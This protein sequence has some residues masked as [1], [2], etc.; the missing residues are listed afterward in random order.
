MELKFP[1]RLFSA[2]AGALILALASSPVRSYAELGGT[3]KVEATAFTTTVTHFHTS[4][5]REGTV[6][7]VTATLHFHN[8]LK[9]PLAIAYEDG[10]AT[11]S[12]YLS[13]EQLDT[14]RSTQTRTVRQYSLTFP[15]LT[16]SN[17]NGALAGV[18]NSQSNTDSNKAASALGGLLGGLFKKH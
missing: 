10:A 13:V 4:T 15:D 17:G 3:P 7:Y 16:R 14:L 1:L 6:R 9:Q 18:T 5:S 8:N 11:V 12:V 2:F